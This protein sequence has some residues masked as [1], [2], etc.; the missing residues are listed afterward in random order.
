MCQIHQHL[1]IFHRLIDYRIILKPEFVT[2]WNHSCKRFK[3]FFCNWLC[4]R[5]QNNAKHKTTSQVS[6]VFD[7]EF[8]DV[9][10]CY[11]IK[12][13]KRNHK[14]CVSRAKLIISSTSGDIELNTGPVITQG[15]N[16][17]NLIA[18][19]QSRLPQHGLRILDV[20]GAG[21]C[22]FR[23]VSHQLYGE[24]SHH[25]NIRSIGVQYKRK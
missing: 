1:K 6:I 25:M 2:S 15:N 12:C 7:D 14:Y 9:V 5:F 18:L 8:V 17:N 16:P 20:G 21:D 19:S 3:V 4:L 13:G 24:P 22:S 10:Q 23:V 11:S